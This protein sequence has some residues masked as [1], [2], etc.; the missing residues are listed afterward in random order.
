MAIS[1]NSVQTAVVAALLADS[2]VATYLSNN[3]AAGEIAEVSYSGVEFLYPA[4]RV[5]IGGRKPIGNGAARHENSQFSVQVYIFDER[6]SSKYV[7][8][9][10]NLVDAALTGKTLSVVGGTS[11]IFDVDDIS[12]P[13]LASNGIWQV[14]I[15]GS[16]RVAG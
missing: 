4:I 5:S 15:T 11:G 3:G 2:S 14:L 9:L 13:S 16:V 1:R 6:P 12:P 8:E 7:S 10:A